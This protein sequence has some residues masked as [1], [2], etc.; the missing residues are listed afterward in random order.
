MQMRMQKARPR[1]LGLMRVA[2]VG[3]VG[4]E[5]LRAKWDQQCRGHA[6]LDRITWFG[7]I[8][9]AVQRAQTSSL[10]G[11]APKVQRDSRP[12]GKE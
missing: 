4:C 3:Y 10:E 7:D 8:H 1:T 6:V 9:A 2:A 12:I 5:D 11:G